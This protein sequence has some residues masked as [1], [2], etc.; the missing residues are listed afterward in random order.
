M[1]SRILRAYLAVRSAAVPAQRAPARVVVT[2]NEMVG[3]SVELR[4]RQLGENCTA[5]STDTVTAEL[6][7]ITARSMWWVD[8][9]NGRQL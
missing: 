1:V 8:V 4:F 5:A 2:G 9:E 6:R 3:D 7:A